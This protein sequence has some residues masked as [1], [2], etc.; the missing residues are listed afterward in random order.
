M[1]SLV[2][3][4]DLTAS[5]TVAGES[6]QKKRMVYRIHEIKEECKLILKSKAYKNIMAWQENLR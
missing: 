4:T 6:P 5:G 3:T 1:E 2:E